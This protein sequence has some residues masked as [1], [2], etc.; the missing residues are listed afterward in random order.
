MAKLN[1]KKMNPEVDNIPWNR[2][3]EEAVIGS[4]ILSNDCWDNICSII[5]NEDFY[6]Y[7]HKK[8][9]KA[10]ESLMSRGKSCDWLTVA[11][12]I[13]NLHGH[14][15]E[16]KL[17]D[18]EI[19]LIEIL[20]DTPTSVN[21]HHYAEIVRQNSIDRKMFD[22]ARQIMV[23]VANKEEGRLDKAQTEILNVNTQEVKKPKLMSE[24]TSA[25]MQKIIEI[26][27]NTITNSG[28]LT[29]YKDL[30]ELT[31]GFKPGNMIILAA[32]PSMGKTLL[33]LNI[34]QHIAEQ[35][36]TIAFFSIEMSQEEIAARLLTSV[37][38]MKSRDIN[39][40][41]YNEFGVE[42][43]T[44]AIN[45]L[46]DLKI[47]IDDSAVTSASI[48]AKCRKI[49]RQHGLDLV[50]VDYLQLIDGYNNLDPVHK[51]TAISRDLK[52]L[53]KELDVPVIAL[54]QLNR[55]LEQRPD[56]RP[57]MADL[58]QSGAI[59]QDAD[60]ILFIYRDEVYNE[61]SDQKGIAEIKLAKNRDGK[62]GTI[63]LV[64]RGD[65]CR[66]ENCDSRYLPPTKP[67]K[68]T[69]DLKKKAYNDFD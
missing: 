34:I 1:P 6:Y 45:E 68:Q 25:L 61:Y 39:T 2:Q 9:F 26:K 32:R 28:L 50:V 51:T 43:I 49:K 66:F 24:L 62:T 36:K 17:E 18:I 21:A 13:V 38:G 20:R 54:S 56:K 69:I 31:M 60:M 63:R 5:T 52:L 3:A 58:R 42:K 8:I 19:C 41:N 22:I 30:D 7:K 40:G 64:F 23:D 57:I 11:E 27:D 4:I 37:S 16:W 46:R 53:A 14:D 15:S 47:I 10:L 48:R 33:A 44:K 55:S 35:K 67:A 12:E 29:N 65:Y 59:E